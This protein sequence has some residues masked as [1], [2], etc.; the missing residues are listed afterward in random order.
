MM[1]SKPRGKNFKEGAVPSTASH[2]AERSRAPG[3]K[4]VPSHCRVHRTAIC[5]TPSIPVATLPSHS[6]PPFS[7]SLQKAMTG[8]WAAC[9]TGR[10]N[11]LTD[12]IFTFSQYEQGPQTMI[13]NIWISSICDLSSYIGIP[14]SP[15]RS[16]A[17]GFI[18][19]SNTLSV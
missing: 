12:G 15:R 19:T 17:A 7:S 14:Q 4:S 13:P 16:N 18:N 9:G 11:I 2:A 10:V 1:S 6:S 8:V 3:R 5:P